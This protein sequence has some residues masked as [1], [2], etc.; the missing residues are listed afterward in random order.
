MEK[1]RYILQLCSVKSNETFNIFYVN[2]DGEDGIMFGHPEQATTYET[3]G[4]AMKVSIEIHRR[5]GTYFR[6]VEY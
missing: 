3:I 5:N 1:K 6:A 2:I 4:E